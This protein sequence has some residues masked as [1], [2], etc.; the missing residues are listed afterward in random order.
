MSMYPQVQS[1]GHEPQGLPVV[2]AVLLF[3]ACGDSSLESNTGIA[4]QDPEFAALPPI[5]ELSENISRTGLDIQP[6]DPYILRTMNVARTR[7]MMCMAI[8][9]PYRFLA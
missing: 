3:S 6:D 8:T 9:E 4:E 1:T 5:E 7:E 2:F